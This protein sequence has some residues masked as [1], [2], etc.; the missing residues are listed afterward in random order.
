M[1]TD[2]K[3]RNKRREE[4]GKDGRK[5]K[6]Y[7]TNKQGEKALSKIIKGKYITQSA[8]KEYSNMGKE[9]TKEDIHRSHLIIFVRNLK[10][11]SKSEEP[12]RPIFEERLRLLM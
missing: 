7:E 4:G 6:I 12:L 5:A 1:R 11:L 10:N 8:Q 2:G 9:M 3:I